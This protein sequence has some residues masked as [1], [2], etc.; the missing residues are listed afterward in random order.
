MQI[1]SPVHTRPTF[2]PGD[3]FIVLG[4]AAILYLGINLAAGAPGRLAG[5][6]IS[7][8]P[9]ALPYY[10]LRSLL[11]M[12]AAYLLSLAFTLTYGYLAA[13][14]RR[15]EA[16]MLPTLDVLQSVPILSF[17]PVVVLSLVAVLPGDAGV[18]LASIV[19]IFTSQVWNMSFSFYNS[20]KTVPKEMNEAANVFHLNWWLRLKTVE[21]P[22]ATLGLVWNSML[23]WA[24][25]WFFLMAAEQFVLGQRDFRLPGLGSYLKTAAEAGD[26][27]AVSWG[28]LVLIALIV[29]LD[30]LVWRPI[31]AWADKFRVAT[32]EVES[33]PRSWVLDLLSR[34]LLIEKL[35]AHVLTPLAEA[36]DRRLGGAP[37]PGVQVAGPA[38]FWLNRVGW[39]VLIAAAIIILFSVGRAAGLVTGIDGDQWL[40][41]LGGGLATFGRVVA[42]LI[43]ALAWT[44]P[45]GVAIGMNHRLAQR[46]V[47]VVQVAASIPAT[48][49]F[50]VFF[51]LLVGLAGGT[52]LA[53]ILLMLL[54]TQWYLL[55]NIIAGAMSIPDDLRYTT[56]TL[57]IKGIEYWH[58]FIVPAL[59]PF[60]VTGMV[61]AAG[62]AWNASIVA[63]YVFFAG[64]GY[65][66]FGLGAII[67]RSSATADFQMLLVSTLAMVTIVVLLN[68][69]FWRR[70][71]MLAE[72]RYHLD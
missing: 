11:R 72:E 33:A 28:L 58:S 30:Q 71:Y 60:L 34:S 39:A 65:S 57:G 45:V 35:Y 23:S 1:Q 59:F 52:N 64:V 42:A 26:F 50:P 38:S 27:Y 6:V 56:T 36:I 43:I 54:G 14:N 13:K 49:L 31:L 25:G 48:A 12:I 70:L 32:V 4:L 63:E 2:K 62:G 10:A 41:I 5:P 9:A 67:A 46:V 61:T 55:F 3:L 21:V 24:G 40:V 29:A 68:R 37:P 44:L 51:S 69:F 18:E 16:V 66:T 19:L 53:A 7:L 22:F 20:L 47:P 15:A 8:D 17:M